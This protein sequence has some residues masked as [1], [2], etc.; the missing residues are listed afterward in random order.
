MCDNVMV[1]TCHPGQVAQLEH[2]PHVP[3]L[4]IPSQ[5]EAP[6]GVNQRMHGRV[7]HWINVSLSLSKKINK[8]F[9]EKMVVHV[10][11]CLSK[12]TEH[13]TPRVSPD[14]N[15]DSGSQ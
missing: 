15:V 14:V 12:L 8:K 10:I 7:D 4:W 5:V 1:V 9:I 2:R 11:K 13:A 6:A 3:G